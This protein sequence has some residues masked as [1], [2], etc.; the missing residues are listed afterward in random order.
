[1]PR[2]L[3]VRYWPSHIMIGPFA[4]VKANHYTARRT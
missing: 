2:H 1:M 3:A 4:Y